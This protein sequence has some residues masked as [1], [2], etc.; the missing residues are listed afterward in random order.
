MGANSSVPAN[1]DAAAYAILAI[2]VVL[3]TAAVLGRVTSRYLMK[4]APATDD[5]LTYLAYVSTWI[6]RAVKLFAKCI[7]DEPGTINIGVFS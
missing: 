5:Y 7:G 6:E 3:T 4:A 2:E 1:Y